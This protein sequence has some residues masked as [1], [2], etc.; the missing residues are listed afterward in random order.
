MKHTHTLATRCVYRLSVGVLI[1]SAVVF[2]LPFWS[3]Q[4]EGEGEEAET[5]AWQG[6]LRRKMKA[7]V[8]VCL[9]AT[10]SLSSLGGWRNR[11]KHITNIR[12]RCLLSLRNETAG[13]WFL[14]LDPSDCLE[15]P[16]SVFQLYFPYFTCTTT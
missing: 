8:L 1:T 5:G 12:S 13:G 10:A 16:P 3:A 2:L 11:E 6:E 4:G 7:F 9:A 15:R 14:L